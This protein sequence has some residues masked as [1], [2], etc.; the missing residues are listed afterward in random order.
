MSKV[1]TFNSWKK[2][3]IV[4]TSLFL[5]IVLLTIWIYVFNIFLSQDIADKKIKLSKV[6][7][8]IKDL[9]KDR[10]LQVYYLLKEN[11]SVIEKLEKRSRV[12]DY[13]NHLIK[14][15]SENSISFSWFNMS[16]GKILTK[17]SSKDKTNNI[18]AY[19]NVKNFIKRYRADEEALFDLE[20]INSFQWMD[21]IDFDVTFSIKENMK[22]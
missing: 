18:L 22:N 2:I 11:A 3:P 6:E 21:E 17:A 14:I 9:K 1:K 8:N 19:M 12:S 7:K 4:S 16:N 5:L 20:F 13:I 10:N 15:S